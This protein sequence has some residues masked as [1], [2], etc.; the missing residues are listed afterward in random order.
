MK[1]VE[2]EVVFGSASTGVPNDG[3]RDEGGETFL[4]RV[5][6]AAPFRNHGQFLQRV[7]EVSNEWLIAGRH[8]ESQRQ[9]IFLAAARSERDLVP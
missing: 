3:I 7:R 2:P 9:A 6:E 8:T 5:W 4:D 1:R